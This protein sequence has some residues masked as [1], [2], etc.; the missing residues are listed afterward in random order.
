MPS[1][2]DQLLDQRKRR[3]SSSQQRKYFVSSVVGHLL[4]TVLFVALPALLAEPPQTFDSIAVTVVPPQALGD[5]NPAPPP[6]PQTQPEP[7][8]EPEPPPPPENK[9]EPKPEELRPVLPR[10]EPA[11][12]K[13]QPERKPQPAPPQEEKRPPAPPR[14]VGSV[15]GDP[16]GA[17]S[18]TAIGVEDPNFTYGYYLDRVSDRINS[19]WRAPRVPDDTR[20]AVL[21]FRILRDGQVQDLAVKETSGSGVFDRRAMAAVEASVPLPP[22]P[23]GYDKEF[24]GINL[25]V[26]NPFSKGRP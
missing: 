4:M 11:P 22:L 23:K 25:I 24:L 26:K 12:P 7:E 18:S 1:H 15:F 19:N 21:Y 2:L 5:P 10:P 3:V 16:L 20:D 13:P 6:P 8:P 17:T 14:R 9:P